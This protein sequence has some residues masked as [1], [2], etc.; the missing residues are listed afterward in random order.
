MLLTAIAEHKPHK[1]S[2]IIAMLIDYYGGRKEVCEAVGLNYTHISSMLTG[3]K[4]NPNSTT[5]AKLRIEETRWRGRYCFLRDAQFPLPLPPAPPASPAPAPTAQLPPLPPASPPTLSGEEF[6]A[7]DTQNYMLQHDGCY[8]DI[9][10]F[11]NERIKQ[12]GTQAELARRLSV[13]KTY[14]SRLVSGDK[15]WPSEETLEKLGV[16]RLVQY[17]FKESIL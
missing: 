2:K 8:P 1:L 4:H 7:I 14:I 6:L 11:V 16:E 12:Y 3:E 9:Q 10:Y 13:S 17:R 5:R 15:D